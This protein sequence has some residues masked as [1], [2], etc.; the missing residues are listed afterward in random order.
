MLLRMLGVG[1][2]RVRYARELGEVVGGSGDDRRD[3]FV[4]PTVRPRASLHAELHGV[5]KLTRSD[6]DDL[7]P[8]AAG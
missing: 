7:D 3:G 2:R 4:T 1:V 5:L 6:G 8:I